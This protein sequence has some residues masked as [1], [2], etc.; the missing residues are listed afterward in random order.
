MNQLISPEDLHTQLSGENPPTVIDVRGEEA[1]QAPATLWARRTFLP[2]TLWRPWHRSPRAGPS[3]PIETWRIAAGRAVSAPPPC[4]VRAAIRPRRWMADSRHGKRRDI[5]LRPV[6]RLVSE[7]ATRQ[8]IAEEQAQ[9]Y[10][11]PN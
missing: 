8:L 5:P 7:C 10:D 6:D 3:S 1:Y 11:H 9:A 2:R 4:S